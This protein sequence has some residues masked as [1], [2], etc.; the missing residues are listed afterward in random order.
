MTIFQNGTFKK[1]LAL[2]ATAVLIAPTA[3][4]DIGVGVGV[5]VGGADVG[6]GASVGGSDGVGA[7]VGA[8]VGGDDGVNAGV[9]ASVGGGHGVGA[10]VGASVGGRHGLGVGVGVGVGGGSGTVGGGAGTGGQ[11]SV[12]GMTAGRA[13]GSGDN[14]VIAP[15]TINIATLV[16]APVWSK[17]RVLVGMVE[18]VAPGPD[19]KVDTVVRLNA[20]L[21][22]DKEIIR[23]RVLPRLSGNGAL[24]LG[25]SKQKFLQLFAG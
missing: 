8:S 16:G 24:R 5:G 19:G 18:K 17:D 25:Y 23:M 3:Q 4:A 15:Q 7:G 2:T 13:N 21:G 6:V 1:T 22:S 12:P 9:G 14:G 11:G 10:G 20:G